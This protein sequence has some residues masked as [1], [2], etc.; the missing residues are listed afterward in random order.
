M[1]YTVYV[2]KE[3]KEFGEVEI[4]ANDENEA[5]ETAMDMLLDGDESIAWQGENM[6][7]GNVY[8]DECEL[9]E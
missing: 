6:E 5:R 2:S 8:V 7:P 1:I 3:W 9:Q 4:E